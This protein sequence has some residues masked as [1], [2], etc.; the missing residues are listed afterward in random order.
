MGSAV[1]IM[2]HCSSRRKCSKQYLIRWESKPVLKYIMIN[3]LVSNWITM[4]VSLYLILSIPYSILLLHFCL[5][6]MH[7]ILKSSGKATSFWGS[8]CSRAQSYFHGKHWKSEERHPEH[9]NKGLSRSHVYL[10]ATCLWN[11]C[12]DWLP[13]T[14]LQ[15]FKQRVWQVPFNCEQNTVYDT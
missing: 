1:S 4:I 6:E 2:W 15:S 5:I 13:P 3:T 10:R 11:S 7:S 14:F 9:N 8:T 12:T